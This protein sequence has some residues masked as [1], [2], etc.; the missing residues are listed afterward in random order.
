MQLNT[1]TVTRPPKYIC[2]CY[3]SNIVG[4][5]KAS[6]S[7]FVLLFQLSKAST[8]RKPVLGLRVVAHETSDEDKNIV[9]V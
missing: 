9:K 5:C 4:Y 7:S 2:L 1:N 3:L 6:I 8:A